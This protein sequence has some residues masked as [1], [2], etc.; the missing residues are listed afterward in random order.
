[1]LSFFLLETFGNVLVQ[2]YEEVLLITRLLALFG[3]WGIFFVLEALALQLIV[4]AEFTILSTGYAEDTV[5][6]DFAATIAI[7]AAL[8]LFS[9]VPAL[10]LVLWL[11]LKER[12]KTA[13]VVGDKTG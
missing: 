11:R 4:P 8:L 5:F 10:T 9:F 2:Q 7:F 13:Y 12:I 3:A 6:S 1:M